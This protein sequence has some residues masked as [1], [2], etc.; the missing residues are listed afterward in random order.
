MALSV[1][2]M[3]FGN[4]VLEIESSV[5]TQKGKQIFFSPSAGLTSLGGSDVSHE[6]V[7]EWGTLCGLFSES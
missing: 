5:V 1:E 2:C 7:R 6:Q 4:T 3:P